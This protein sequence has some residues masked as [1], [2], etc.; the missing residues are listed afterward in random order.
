MNPNSTLPQ[1]Q[2]APNLGGPAGPIVDQYQTQNGHV[3]SQFSDNR[4]DWA[5]EQRG[6]LDIAAAGDALFQEVVNRVIQICHKRIIGAVTMFEFR[7]GSGDAHH[8]NR[9]T[10]GPDGK[11]VDD[12]DNL[13][14]DDDLTD[15]E[16]G[17]ATYVK[18]SFP[19]K[20][21]LVCGSVTRKVIARGRGFADVFAIELA[22][23]VERATY[24]LELTTFRGNFGAAAP[25]E[26]DG[27][28]ELIGVY[29]GT[30]VGQP[31]QVATGDGAVG[32]VVPALSV[33]GNLTLQILDRALDEIKSGPAAIF[34]S[35][36]GGRIIN[37]LLQATQ[38]NN[39]KTVVAGGFRVATYD[40]HP[41]VKTDGIP[42]DMA[43]GLDGSGNP[44]LTALSGALANART[45]AVI[46]TQMDEVFYD[47]LTP[48][49]V[50][51]LDRCTTQRR[52]FEAYWDGTLVLGCPEGAYMIIGI[53]PDC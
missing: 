43:W 36:C 35:K 12:T 18:V 39:D 46:V 40:D 9:Q 48:L 51:P 41:I 19:Y 33:S 8:L 50:E 23:A 2:R 28:F 3:R 13:G 44:I 4:P 20:C 22:H 27:L 31:I 11:W 49:T 30:P 6:I 26:F 25:K 14:C 32:N 52:K 53:L 16:C 21:M 37:G 47:E 34:V 17:P 42:D 10:P 15:P 29:N 1:Q 24:T 38:Q 7:R 45:T 5:G